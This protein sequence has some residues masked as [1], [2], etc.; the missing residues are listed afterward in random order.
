M[1]CANLAHGLL[2]HHLAIVFFLCPIPGSHALASLPVGYTHASIKGFHPALFSPCTLQSTYRAANDN[3]CCLTQS[4]HGYLPLSHFLTRR[5][6]G[7]AKFNAA[8]I[9][10]VYAVSVIAPTPACSR[11]S[12]SRTEPAA[13]GTSTSYPQPPCACFCAP[14]CHRPV[15]NAT[16]TTRSFRLLH[17]LYS[18]A[19]PPPLQGVALRCEP[20]VKMPVCDT[21]APVHANPRT[22]PRNR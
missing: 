21:A 8:K 5:S 3:L 13:H 16:L 12:H 4:P 14:F 7:S 1:L 18:Q 2:L 22:P 19:L 11:A 15:E 10:K 9:Q 17:N 6:I 20:Q